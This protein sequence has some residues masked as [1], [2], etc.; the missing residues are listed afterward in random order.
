M[1]APPGRLGV[2]VSHVRPRRAGDAAKGYVW[3]MEDVS[4]RRRAD[5]ALERLVREQDAVLQNAVTGIIFVRDRRI[6]RANRRFEEL[7]LRRG[8]A[9]RPFHALHVRNR[10]G[11]RGGRRA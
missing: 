5:Q 8:R 7:W 1:A 6:V 4:E 3:L 2:L 11:V 9:H 10:R